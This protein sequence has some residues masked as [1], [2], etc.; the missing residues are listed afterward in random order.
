[1]SPRSARDKATLP[2]CQ[3]RRRAHTGYWREARASRVAAIRT[4]KFGTAPRNNAATFSYVFGI[5]VATVKCTTLRL[6]RTTSVH[7]R[8]D[9][10]SSSEA[11][12]ASAIAP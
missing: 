10:T 8:A 2:Y 9:R 11:P 7:S 4:R 5:G 1:M 3:D 12:D 6:S